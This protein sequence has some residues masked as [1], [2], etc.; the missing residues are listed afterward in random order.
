MV[1]KMSTL[2]KTDRDE[3]FL[4]AL[5][6]DNIIVYDVTNAKIERIELSGKSA[7]L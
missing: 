6:A 4:I 3:C 5:G 7:E 1:T 2:Q